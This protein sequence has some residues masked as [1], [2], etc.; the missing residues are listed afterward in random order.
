MPKKTHI[1]IEA[2]KAKKPDKVRKQRAPRISIVHP[3][4]IQAKKVD[5]FNQIKDEIPLLEALIKRINQHGH[6]GLGML[7]LAQPQVYN[8]WPLTYFMDRDFK[9]YINPR[10]LEESEPT[11]SY[12]Q[13]LSYPFRGKKKLKRFYKIKVEFWDHKMKKYTEEVTGLRAAVFQHE[14][15]H[16]NGKTIYDY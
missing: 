9:V 13:C 2:P 5:S 3:H 8:E 15:D 11:K 7:A 1:E 10:I 4:K 12:E 14:I 16:F 6:H